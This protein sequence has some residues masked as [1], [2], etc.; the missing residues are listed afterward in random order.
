[1]T[2]RPAFVVGVPEPEWHL[3][4][5]PEMLETYV[6][7]IRRELGP[8]GHLI[9]G[10][11][12]CVGRGAA[13]DAVAIVVQ[14]ATVA[15]PI[16]YFYVHEFF[17][18]VVRIWRKL[19]ER[20][21]VPLISLGSAIQLCGEDLRQRLPKDSLEGVRCV[22]AAD[23]TPGGEHETSH[24]GGG[25]FVVIFADQNTNWTY[26]VSDKGEVINYSQGPPLPTTA[27]YLSNLPVD[28]DKE[29]PDYP[30]LGDTEA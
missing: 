20:G 6:D 5:T 2:T 26:L 9:T 25:L 29:Q 1:M 10:E 14:V 11:S 8:D 7:E 18:A 30:L 27:Q 23:H 15:V 28:W 16:T 4:N 21:E 3:H 19:R 13:G 12:A 17:P 22:S 24:T